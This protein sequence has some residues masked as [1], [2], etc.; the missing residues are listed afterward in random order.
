MQKRLLLLALL[1]AGL[2]LLDACCGENKPYFDYQKLSVDSDRVTLT[3]TGD[4]VVTLVVAPDEV[5]YLA[6]SYK[7]T[8]T[9]PAYGTSCP[10]PG[11]SGP[12]S[13]MTLVEI[14]AEQNFNDTMPAGKSLSSLFYDARSTSTSPISKD[15]SSLEFIL[16]QWDFVIYTPHKPKLIDETYSF[17]VKVTQADG[18]FAQGRVTGVKFK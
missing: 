18:T 5:D 16:P 1:C 6:S 8:V 2:H 11:E 13:A 15:Y 4:T 7:L 14:F 12:K 9:T 3:T 10:D 17:T